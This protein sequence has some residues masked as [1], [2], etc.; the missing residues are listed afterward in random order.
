[1]HAPTPDRFR[2]VLGRFPA[3]V[4]VM[5][6]VTR[7]GVPHGMTASAVASVSIEPPLVLVCVDRDAS[8]AAAVAEAGSFALS[9]LGGGQRALSEHFADP[10]RGDG[11]TQF[12]GVETTTAATGSP[13]LARAH[14]W[15]DCAVWATYDGGDHV[16]VVGEVVALAPGSI[17]DA[18]VHH[19]SGYA[20][21]GPDTPVPAT[22]EGPGPTSEVSP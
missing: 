6:T 12:A 1:M 7:D 8:M 2:E 22:E 11:D 19:R 20:V 3:G 14:G 17:D 16:I 5:T 13:L 18:L 15:I 21:A 10:A 4:T 9:I